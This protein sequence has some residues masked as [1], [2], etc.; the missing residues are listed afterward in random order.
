[1]RGT[2]RM[3]G[4]PVIED[5]EKYIRIDRFSVRPEVAT[6]RLEATNIINGQPELSKFLL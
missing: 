1:M 2:W 3:T 6:A 5:G 4:V